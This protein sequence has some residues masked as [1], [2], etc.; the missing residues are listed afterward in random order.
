MLLRIGAERN[1]SKMDLAAPICI[2]LDG[3]AVPSPEMRWFC[4]ERNI[5]TTY[6]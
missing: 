4:A 2:K 3:H 6:T 5:E 1:K